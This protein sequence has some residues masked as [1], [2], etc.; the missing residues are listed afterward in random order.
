MKAST[1]HNKYKLYKKQHKY[2]LT[3]MQL[4]FFKKSISSQQ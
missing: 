3:C 2:M 1:D 4:I